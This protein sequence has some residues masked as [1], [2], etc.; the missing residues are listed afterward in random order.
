MYFYITTILTLSSM[1]PL[2]T[3]IHS[4]V[5]IEGVPTA[6][7]QTCRTFYPLY[8]Y[9]PL[10]VIKETR[11]DT[12]SYSIFGFG[13]FGPFVQ[14]QFSRLWTV[15]HTIITLSVQLIP[16]ETFVELPKVLPSMFV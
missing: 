15:P 11:P 1:T 2:R 14:L 12:Q 4:K 6:H 8:S 9:F 3:D 7:S 13:G 10:K 5:E 16:C